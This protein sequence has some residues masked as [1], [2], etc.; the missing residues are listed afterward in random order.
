MHEIMVKME[1]VLLA[2]VRANE[3]ERKKLE[4]QI[5]QLAK[6]LQGNNTNLYQEFYM[7]QIEAEIHYDISLRTQSVQLHSHA[8]YEV[9]FCDG[10]NVHYLLGSKRYKLRRGD[11]LLIPPG[12]SHR[13]LFLEQ[14][15]EPYKRFA[16]W[17]DADFLQHTAQRYPDCMFAFLQCEKQDSYLLRT[18]Q[19]TWEGLHAGFHSLWQE[20][21][22]HRLGWQ[23]CVSAG[24]L[25]L[26]A[27]ISRTYYYLDTAAPQAESS[28]LADNIFRFIDNNLAKKITLEEVAAHFF[29]SKSTVS[30]LFKEQMGVSFYRCVIQRRLIAA[31]N[32][33]QHEVPLRLIWEQ[34]GFADYS[35]FYRL[36]KKEYG[37]S[38]QQF[39]A[40]SQR[41]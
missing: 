9:L 16:L 22:Q 19:P 30:H 5:E 2:Y 34:C 25:G 17:L 18:P 10:G 12:M 27:H 15:T 32:E 33:I 24:A 3:Q 36:F 41:V 39:R 40:L 4:P 11:V 31:K 13:P 38:P 20:T 35:S 7:Q 23:L 29:V 26:L 1:E 14:L 37:V 6:A 21:Q 28:N 8:F